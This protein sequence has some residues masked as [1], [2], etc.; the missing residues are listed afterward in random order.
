MRTGTGEKG[1]FVPRMAGLAIVGIYSKMYIK[2]WKDEPN[3]ICSAHYTLVFFLT[4]F[5]SLPFLSQKESTMKGFFLNCW[6][7]KPENYHTI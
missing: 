6:Q 5:D 2:E 7:I 4:L 3:N 1:S